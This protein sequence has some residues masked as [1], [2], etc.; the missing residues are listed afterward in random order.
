MLRIFADGEN[1]HRLENADGTHAGSIRGRSIR[2]V[3]LHSEPDAIA[4]A[5]VIAATV[6]TALARH[7]GS[8]PLPPFALDALR[9]VHDGAY[10]WVSDGGRPIARLIRP[11]EQK[12]HDEG[13]A[14]EFVLP[15]YASEGVVVSIAQVMAATLAEHAT[16]RAVRARRPDSAAPDAMAG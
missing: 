4:A 1:A 9:V 12:D 16:P 11:S 7:Y 8:P 3:G 2:L 14:I 10:D 5:V 6:D 13:Y 15:S